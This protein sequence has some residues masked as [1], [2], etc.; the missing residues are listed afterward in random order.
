MKLRHHWNN[1]IDYV[2]NNKKKIIIN[3]CVFFAVA[4][5]ML[6]FDL[7]TKQFLFKNPDNLEEP[8]IQYTHGPVQ[9]DFGIIGIRS[10]INE[11]LTFF[12]STSINVLL[13]T[14]FNVIILIGC[15]VFILFFNSTWYSVFI[16][17]IFAGALGNTIDRLTFGW[18]RDIIF[19][20][21]FDNG[22]FNVADV[23][24]IVGC[25]GLVITLVT[26]FLISYWKKD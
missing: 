16:G 15:I 7:L 11:G 8:G 3:Y 5:L 6:V 22:T 2:D 4:I 23:L 25:V 19:T 10:V 24:V 13:V 9:H 20:P 21:W 26:Q 12:P 1:F 17:C 18:V 14:F